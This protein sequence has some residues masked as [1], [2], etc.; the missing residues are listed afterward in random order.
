MPVIFA[1]V[2]PSED[3][4]FNPDAT[5]TVPA[6]PNADEKAGL[7]VGLHVPCVRQIR[8]EGTA[9]KL[10]AK[11]FSAL[12][13]CRR[14]ARSTKRPHDQNRRKS[15]SFDSTNRASHAIPPENVETD[16]ALEAHGPA[17]RCQQQ[18]TQAGP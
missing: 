4:A 10:D 5:A 13:L 15:P 12:A 18:Q 7:V 2:C 6:Q 3:V 17:A 14:R 11:P 1:P 8:E 9:D 16:I